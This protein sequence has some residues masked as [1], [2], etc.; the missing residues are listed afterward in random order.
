MVAVTISS[1]NH[2]SSV[3]IIFSRTDVIAV[4]AAFGI[5][6]KDSSSGGEN[7]VSNEASEAFG[8][9][10]DAIKINKIRVGTQKAGAK[11][12]T[13]RNANDCWLPP[14]PV[15]P[16]FDLFCRMTVFAIGTSVSDTMDASQ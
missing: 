7:D 15:L 16:A 13:Y 14:D 8:E 6:T 10:R 1:G 11:S 12:C 4:A 3:T 9:S 5:G 2:I